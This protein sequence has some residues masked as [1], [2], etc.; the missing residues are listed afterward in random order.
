GRAREL[1]SHPEGVIVRD[2]LGGSRD[3]EYGLKPHPLMAYRRPPSANDFSFATDA[4]T[5]EAL[6]VGF[7]EWT[8]RIPNPQISICE[9]END[10]IV[11]SR[12]AAHRI[13]RVLQQL[14]DEP[15]AVVVGDLRLLRDILAQPDRA[16]A[17][18]GE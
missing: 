8:T 3:L 14:V 12:L 17:V 13:V 1:G 7:V 6:H 15:A 16:R 9:T 4:D 10:P 5:T 18:D 2:D 11:G